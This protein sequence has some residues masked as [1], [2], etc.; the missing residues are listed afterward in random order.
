MKPELYIRESSPSTQKHE[1]SA[2]RSPS[3]FS[4]Y[5]VW[6]S[7]FGRFWRQVKSCSDRQKVISLVLE[8]FL[9]YSLPFFYPP[10]VFKICL[11]HIIFTN[12]FQN[13]V[14]LENVKALI[15]CS[16]KLFVTVIQNPNTFVLFLN[17]KFNLNSKILDLKGGL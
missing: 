16:F 10:L 2:L 3:F 4:W 12:S 9:T 8:M 15:L 11:Q 5:Y 7:R 14:F 17:K 1:L 13:S 6:A